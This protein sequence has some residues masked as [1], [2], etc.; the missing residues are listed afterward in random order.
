M[1]EMVVG[2]FKIYCV[3]VISKCH[4]GCI[5]A[6]DVIGPLKPRGTGRL[7][8]AGNNQEIQNKAPGWGMGDPRAISLTASLPPGKACY[9]LKG[10][11]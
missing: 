3:V 5:Q 1:R 2:H 10:D 6:G 11:K 7:S 8:L 4:Q 9:A